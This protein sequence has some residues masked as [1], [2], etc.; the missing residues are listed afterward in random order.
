MTCFMK[1]SFYFMIKVGCGDM[2]QYFDNDTTIKSQERI[3]DYK[4]GNY[5]FRFHS[6]NGVFSKSEVDYGTHVL[7]TNFLANKKCETVLDMGG[8][9]GVISV[10]LA[11]ILHCKCVMSEINTRACELARK[12]VKFNGVNDLVEVKESDAYKN[13]E[14]K[15]DVVITNPPIRAGKKVV[16]EFLLKSIDYLNDQGELWFVIRKNHGE[17][18]AKRDVAKVFGNCEIIKRDKGFYVLRAIKNN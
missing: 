7:I 8:G 5:G 6:D 15:Y 4:V 13:I 16:Y 2:S 11:K 1:A 14:G 3:I 9:I 10:V 12:N 18:S 17:E